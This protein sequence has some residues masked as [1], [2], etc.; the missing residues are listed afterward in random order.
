[1]RCSSL[2]DAVIPTSESSQSPARTSA[3]WSAGAAETGSQPPG[4]RKTTTSP[5]SYPVKRGVSSSTR[6]RSFTSSVCSID[7][8]GM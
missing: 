6:M 2:S 7:P 5:R 4:S 8:D 1:M 3:D